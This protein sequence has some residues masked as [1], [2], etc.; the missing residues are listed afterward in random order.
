MRA[1]SGYLCPDQ[2]LHLWDVILAFGTVEVLPVLALAI[3]SF[4]RDNL[5]DVTSQ[6][7]AEVRE[8]FPRDYLDMKYIYI[9]IYIYIYKKKMGKKIKIVK[10]I[11]K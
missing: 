3:V 10:Y 11:K 5:M 1:F 2:L 9:Y 6:Q 4:R 7:A 8:F